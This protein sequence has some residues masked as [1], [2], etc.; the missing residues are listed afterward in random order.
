VDKVA[1]LRLPAAG[2]LTDAII[3]EEP[4]DPNIALQA[5][6]RARLIAE[7]VAAGGLA[8][9]AA[10][11]GVDHYCSRC[12]WFKPNSTNLI[13]GCPGVG[14]YVPDPTFGGILSK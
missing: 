4:F 13:T 2:E 9:A 3:R 1:L 14:S 10:L 7:I 6:S 11:P 12:E 5:L 8:T